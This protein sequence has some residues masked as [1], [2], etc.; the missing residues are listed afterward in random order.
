MISGITALVYYLWNS[1]R[2]KS[3]STMVDL[4]KLKVLPSNIE[5]NVASKDAQTEKSLIEKMKAHGKSIVIF[6][7]S[8]T[9]TAEEFAQ[10]LAKNARL[11]GLKALVVDPEEIDIVSFCIYFR[12]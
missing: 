4:K 8:Q 11:Y 6:F 10:R 2:S 1:S 9:G 5:D 12:I 7:G 3:N